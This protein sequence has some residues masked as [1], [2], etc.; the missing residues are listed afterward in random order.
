MMRGRVSRCRD[1]GF[2]SA[3]RLAA[4]ALRDERD[5]GPKVAGRAISFAGV[6]VLVIGSGLGAGRNALLGDA[7]VLTNS[8]SYSFYL[9][10]SR[11]VLE[12]HDPLTLI[13]WVFA[14]GT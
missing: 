12:R 8:L 7:L 14:L 9:V 4:V 10:L 6:A 1:R 13:A 11:P 2:I 3:A 5:Q